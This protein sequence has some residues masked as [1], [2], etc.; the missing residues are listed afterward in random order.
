MKEILLNQAGSRR[1]DRFGPPRLRRISPAA[2][3]FVQQ[4]GKALAAWGIPT[5]Q[6]KLFV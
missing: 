5:P 1:P 6:A 2:P 3:S 4:T